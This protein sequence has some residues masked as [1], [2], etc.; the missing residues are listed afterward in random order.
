MVSASDAMLTALFLKLLQSD[1]A[2]ML[3]VFMPK[4]AV[5]LDFRR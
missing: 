3:L 5:L 1:R 4:I 2:A